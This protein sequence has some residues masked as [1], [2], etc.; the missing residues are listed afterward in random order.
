[1]NP[2]FLGSKAK[3][4]FLWLFTVIAADAQ[5]KLAPKDAVGSDPFANSEMK[6][7]TFQVWP[8][9]LRSIQDSGKIAIVSGDPFATASS[10]GGVKEDKKSTSRQSTRAILEELGIPFPAGATAIFDPLNHQLQVRHTPSALGVIDA[11][12]EA[13]A[14]NFPV[15]AVLTVYLIQ[16]PGD[17]LRRLSRQVPGNFDQ[18]A[19]LKQLLLDEVNPESGVRV[20]H[21]ACVQT[22]SG[23]RTTLETGTDHAYAEQ[24][25]VGEKGSSAVSTERRLLGFK[26]EVDPHFRRPSNNID[27]N[28]SIE[29]TSPLLPRQEVSLQAP[30]TSQPLDQPLPFFVSGKVQ[31]ATVLKSGHSRLLAVWKPQEPVGPEAKDILHGV[32]ITARMAPLRSRPKSVTN[33]LKLDLTRPKQITRHIFTLPADTWLWSARNSS[34]GKADIARMFEQQYIALP[35]GSRVE[36]NEKK[37]LIAHGD[38]ETLDVL[39]QWVIEQWQALP[40]NLGITMHIVR[41]PGRI[42]RPWLNL[43]DSHAD[44]S[45]AIDE[46]RSAA[47]KGDVKFVST[48]HIQGRSGQKLTSKARQDRSHVTEI[49]WAHARPSVSAEVRPLGTQVELEPVISEH[50]HLI[51]VPFEFEWQPAAAR[52]RR[53]SFMDPASSIRYEFPR[54]DFHMVRLRGSSTFTEGSTKIVGAWHPRGSA[55]FEATDTME[56]LFMTVD[57]LSN[58]SPDTARP[59]IT[60]ED[61]NK[62]VMRVF[63]V[64]PDFLLSAGVSNAA[65]SKVPSNQQARNILEALGIPFPE[66]SHAIYTSGSNRL[67]VLNT[68]DNLDL[69]EAF[70]GG[71]CYG[72]KSL[73]FTLHLI[74]AEG[75][76]IRDLLQNSANRADHTLELDQM[77]KAIES[78]RAEPLSTL[79]TTTKGGQRAT[80]EETHEHPYIVALGHDEKD[81]PN[82]EREMALVGTRMEVDPVIGADGYTIDINLNSQFS[83]VRPLLHIE[84]LTPPDAA[85]P[86]KI[87]L[88]DFHIEEISTAL[89]MTSGT[90]RILA[91]WKPT[92]RPEFEEKDLLHIAILE[93]RVVPVEE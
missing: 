18:S 68:I 9:V 47:V 63:R 31:T 42:L 88:T 22:K 4:L 2:E 24:A 66:G 32:F 78:D 87:P 86:S 84:M 92:G 82:I 56:V 28:V 21:T 11:I 38:L 13:Q 12:I 23:Q 52:Q 77:L 41:G 26:V 8:G 35:K 70:V 1:M 61:R 14:V 85:H 60:P 7:Q 49:H 90:A 46:A 73:G 15:N 83:P 55:G 89:T 10:S 59:A 53:E 64:P 29:L 65:K 20:L 74:Q 19:E 91:V 79:N 27:L 58:L 81:R 48:T 3:I 37:Q 72:V 17:V 6:I 25:E 44:H 43:E 16:A 36:T 67:S 50:G 51:D 57:V 34:T 39:Q 93:A 54:E 76:M 5:D 75:S 45:A 62:M 80:V 69:I 40:K 33:P 30:V 71:C